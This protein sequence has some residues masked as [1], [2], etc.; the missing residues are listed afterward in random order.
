[1][2]TAGLATLSM[3]GFGFGFGESVTLI[4]AA[5]YA[6]HIIGLGRYCSPASAAGL[7][8]VQMVVIAMVSLVAAAPGGIELPDGAGASPPARTART[9]ATPPA[10]SWGRCCV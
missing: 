7:A 3:T 5:F 9:T 2:A 6:L 10:A 4:A 8:V 1:M